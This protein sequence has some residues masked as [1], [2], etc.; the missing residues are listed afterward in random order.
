M[1]YHLSQEAR[2]GVSEFR[3]PR[4]FDRKLFPFQKAA[5]QIAAHHLNRPERG[6]VLIGDV[7][8]LGKTLMATAVVRVFEEDH[9]WRTLILC[10]K[11]LVGMWRSYREEYGMSAEVMSTSNVLRKLSE[12]RGRYH[13]LVIDESQNLRNREGQRYRAIR[14]FIA[15][16]DCRVVLLSATPYNKAYS[17]LANQLRLFVPEDRDLGI[18]PEQYIKNRCDGS[19]AAFRRR[20]QCSP[21][22]IAA[23]EPSEYPDDWRELMRLFMVRRTRR[24][25]QNQ[26]EYVNTDPATGRK[27]LTFEDGRRQYFPERQ[28]KTMKFSVNDGNP[29]D[30]YAQLY[31]SDVVDT[32]NVLNLPRYGLGK[33]L[34]GSIGKTTPDEDETIARLSRAGK[35]LIGYC[36]TNLFKRLESSGAAFVQSVERHILRNYVYLHAI[37][38]GEPLPVGTQDAGLLDTRFSDKDEDTSSLFD[39]TGEEEDGNETVAGRED[40]LRLEKDFR[41]RAAEVYSLYSTHAQRRF[42]WLRPSLFDGKALRDTLQADSGALM[43]I[44]SQCGAWDAERDAKLEALHDLI[45]KSHPHDKVI[46]FTQF[47]D[48][49]RYLEGELTRRGVRKLSGVT[50]ESADPTALAH[51]FSPVSNGQRNKIKPEDE[52]RVLIATDVLSEGQNLQDG[53]IVVNYD[54]PWAI[55][56]LVQRAGRVDRIGQEAESI[57]CYT[58]LP[59]EGVEH[60]I[61]LRSRVRARLRENAEV[62][63][64][65]EAF[66]EDDH[67]DQKVLDLY[68]EK[69]GLLDDEEDSETDLTSQAYQI[70]QNAIKADPSLEQKIKNMPHVVYSTK[71]V[72]PGAATPEGALVFVRTGEGNNALAWLDKDGNVVT[73][74]QFAVLR[75][76]ECAPDTPAL[77]RLEN[78]HELVRKAVELIGVAEAAPGGQLGPPSSPRRRAYERLKAY[79]REIKDTLFEPRE[80][81]EAIQ[82]I[83]AHPLQELARDTLVRQLKSGISDA[84]LADLVVSRRSEGQLCVTDK[85][86]GT[87]APQIICSLGLRANAG[88]T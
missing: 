9:D 12:L 10:P 68:H 23:F 5:V 39:D 74:S 34:A 46:V 4:E 66:F 87:G 76:A 80:L 78:H 63:G 72:H 69:A 62:V 79:A 61:R 42:R 47:A 29:T 56:R 58:F 26:P 25:I 59:A 14:E 35:R 88:R 38:R 22:S 27:Y 82:D 24:F 86:R 57:L 16:H 2:L 30:Q 64:T 31:A 81:A 77:P 1:A 44:L 32:I 13:L 55:I 85:E 54:L 43:S 7:V 15:L 45:T 60:I 50:G 75:A 48:T 49:V 8:G 33:Y 6:G 36:R 52:L 19:E 20:H 51:R 11:N 17:D 70:W 40:S 3:I 83:Y 53:Y 71:P 84:A 21:R 67:D 65:D 28:L 73:E 37:E 41:R 18:R